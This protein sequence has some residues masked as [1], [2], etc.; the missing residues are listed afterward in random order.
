MFLFDYRA[1]FEG[2]EIAFSIR[3]KLYW[4]R[5]TIGWPHEMVGKCEGRRLHSRAEPAAFYRS[6]CGWGCCFAE[7][8]GEKR[9][10]LLG[11]FKVKRAIG[12]VFVTNFIHGF[13]STPTGI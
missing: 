6:R 8:Q 7:Q 3:P 1:A 10:R 11:C 13:L 2:I 12:A 4:E 9:Q 5:Q